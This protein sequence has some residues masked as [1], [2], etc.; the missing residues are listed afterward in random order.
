MLTTEQNAHWATFGFLTLPQQFSSDE[1]RE[2]ATEVIEQERGGE[3]LRGKQEW[4]IGGFLERHPL[5]TSLLDDDRIYGIPE[6]LLGP[7]FVL[8]MTDG[9]VRAG[10]TSWHGGPGP[11]KTARVCI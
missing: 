9:H 11:L 8:E 2:A 4:S 7:D 5:L 3:A 6:A 1:M 10:D